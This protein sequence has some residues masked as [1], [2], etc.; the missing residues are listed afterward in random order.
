MG[1][2]M[3]SRHED[4]D[5]LPWSGFTIAQEQVLLLRCRLKVETSLAMTRDQPPTASESRE[6]TGRSASM[7]SSSPSPRVQCRSIQMLTIFPPP[8]SIRCHAFVTA[9]DIGSITRTAM[10]WL[11]DVA[12]LIRGGGGGGGSR[13]A[14][15]AYFEITTATL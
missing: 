13:G 4:G 9:S 5:A 15:V 6:S 12:C 7:S 10:R 3:R 8:P 1:T 14:D 2:R 11:H